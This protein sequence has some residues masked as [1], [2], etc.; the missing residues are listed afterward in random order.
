MFE[1]LWTEKYRPHTL[2]DIILPDDIKDI[3]KQAKEV[4]AIPNL[5]FVSVPGTGKTSLAKILVNDILDCQYMYINASDEN[6]IDTIRTKITN[7][8][9]TMS[10]DGKMKVIILDEAD[11]ITLD[12]QNALRNTMEEHADITRFI[13]TANYDYKIIKALRSRCE[14]Y[15]FA[16]EIDKI[17]E[18]IIYILEQESI[19]WEEEDEKTLRSIVKHNYPDIRKIIGIVRQSSTT[20]AFKYTL[21]STSKSFLKE[22]TTKCIKSPLSVRQYAINNEEE[23]SGDYAQLLRAFFNYVDETIKSEDVRQKI[24]ITISDYI[25][26]SSF[27]MDQE[28]N[29]YACCLEINEIL[30]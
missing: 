6:G 22:L 4:G 27:V 24:L 7:F 16:P 1:N 15:S 13:L 5:L 28:I 17:V 14:L 21:K 19:T 23:F 25:Y 26:K 10:L 30:K 18:R 29:F 8:S 9:Q 12:G 11:G 3:F 2:E 20:G